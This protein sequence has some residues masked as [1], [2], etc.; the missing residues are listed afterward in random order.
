MKKYSSQKLLLPVAK[1]RRHLFNP[2]K[3]SAEQR[4]TKPVQAQSES[5]V[6]HLSPSVSKFKNNTVAQINGSYHSSAF[7]TARKIDTKSVSFSDQQNTL[8]DKPS[9]E[10]FHD[11]SEQNIRIAGKGTK[12]TQAAT[13]IQQSRSNTELME[14]E[15]VLQSG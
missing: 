6:N 3:Q 2:K 8:G 10:L 7:S 11:Q 13:F 12:K 14:V 15:P 9:V 1:S 5:Q 4:V